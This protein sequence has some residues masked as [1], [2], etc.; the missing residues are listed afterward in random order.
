[1]KSRLSLLLYVFMFLMFS[2]VYAVADDIEV[3]LEELL[4]DIEEGES[5]EVKKIICSECHTCSE[6]EKKKEDPPKP[7]VESWDLSLLLG[8]NLSTGN[9]DTSL[10][11]GGAKAFRDYEKNIIR[12]EFAGARGETD[13]EKTEE[14]ISAN[15]EY[16]R[17]IE[18]PFYLGMG[19][20]FLSD[21]IADV[22][23]RVILKP[24]VGV[25]LIKNDIVRL[26]FETGPGYVFEK[27]AGMKNDYFSPRIANR[28]DWNIAS[29]S[30]LFQS[31]EYLFNVDDGD[32]YLVTAEAGIEAAISSN[33]ALVCSV[34]DIYDN[35][36]AV[37]LKRNDVSVITSL[38]LSL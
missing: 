2:S 16:N 23:Y 5:E 20:D 21:G 36:P 30:K 19:V 1:M 13:N 26:S 11:H 22:D 7:G 33:L 31:A 29:N 35:I 18:D 14:K 25:F 24:V 34:K 32:D 12:A 38:K 4:A 27:L 6:C 17:I 3:P 37:G 10:L 15:L 9:T 8:Y 28:F